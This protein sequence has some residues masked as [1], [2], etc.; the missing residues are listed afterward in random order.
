MNEWLM[1]LT[2]ALGGILFPAGGT[3]IPKI[4]GQKWLRRFILAAAFGGLAYW[5]GIVWWRD[6]ILGIGLCIAFHL[7]YGSRSSYLIKTLTA[8]CFVL[9]TFA[10]GFN[11]WQV[12][13][14]AAFLGMF[15][16]SNSRYWNRL[17]SWKIVE[18]LTGSYI[19]VTIVT[20]IQQ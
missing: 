12:F 6:L 10:L 17:F 7:P 4:G 15:W 20:L 8:I 13:T 5:A 3:D 16:L 1:I 19:A 9:P 2:M 11:L 14:P 18:F